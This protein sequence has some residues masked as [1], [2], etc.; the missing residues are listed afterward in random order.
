MRVVA[1]HDLGDGTSR[2]ARTRPAA[3]RAFPGGF[4]L[5]RELVILGTLCLIYEVLH[6]NM[7][8]AGAAATRHALSIVHLEADVRI[9]DERSVQAAFLHVPDI[10]RLFNLYYGGTHFVVPA[11]VLIWLAMRHPERYARS[12]TTLALITGAAFVCFWLFPVA[13]PR[14]L[15][16]RFGIID[17]LT[18]LGKSGHYAGE[19]IDAVGDKYA[20][21]PSL[22]VGWAVWCALALYPV[23]RHRTLRVILVAYPFLTTLVVVT[24][25][26]HFFCD[27]AAGAL[28][29][30]VTW[31]LVS[32]LGRAIAKWRMNRR[33]APA[34]QGTGLTGGRLAAFW[35]AGPPSGLPRGHARPGR[36]RR[37]VWRKGG[38]AGGY[39]ACSGPAFVPLA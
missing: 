1:D 39:L 3:R 15:P 19:L 2:S 9:F 16:A 7:V 18:S 8:Q 33:A 23:V 22:H 14:L 11:A 34:A 37:P 25:G 27:A 6:D 10:V 5:A 4:R 38:L 26:N 35:P 12:R 31:I 24:T 28:L 20:A 30:A 32:R 21:M 36:R 17:T 29:A 13:P